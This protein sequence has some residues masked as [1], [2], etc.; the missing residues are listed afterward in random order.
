MAT[1]DID[2]RSP[3]L[4]TAGSTV[5]IATVAGLAIFGIAAASGV[6]FRVRPPGSD[7]VMEI[8]AV[9]VAVTIILTTALGWAV[10]AL[11]RRVGRPNLGAIGVIATVFAVI[12]VAMPLAAEGD[13]AARLVLAALHLVTGAVFVAGVELLRRRTPSGRRG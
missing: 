1:E 10:V 11:A 13:V 7:A 2:R 9:A 5:L 4:R 8:N 6:D 3:F 12:S